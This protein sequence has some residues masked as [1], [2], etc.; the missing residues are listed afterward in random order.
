MLFILTYSFITLSKG[1]LLVYLLIAFQFNSLTMPFLILI[2]VYLAIAGAIL[3][4]FVTQTPISFLA[5]TG[6]VSL[7]GIVVRNSL[8]LV[9]FIEQSIKSNSTI[10]EAVVKS[11]EAR[12][13]PIGLTTITSIIALT[14]V[15]ISGDVLFQPLAITIISGIAF[16]T[17]LTLLLVPVLYMLFK[18]V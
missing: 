8:V 5:I 6:M 17:V 3:G 4:L 12:L 10:N 11:V 15:A 16:S 2:S 14:P 18:R 1:V 7:T 9:D 13:R